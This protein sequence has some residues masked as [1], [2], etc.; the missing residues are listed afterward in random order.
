MSFSWVQIGNNDN[1]ELTEAYRDVVQ[2]DCVDQFVEYGLGAG[3]I[4]RIQ[5][6]GKNIGTR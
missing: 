4:L 6:G 3:K 5:T 2:G 1:R